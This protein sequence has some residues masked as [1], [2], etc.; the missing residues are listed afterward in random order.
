MVKV[1]VVSKGG[2]LKESSVKN[3]KEND[4]YK[5]GS[6]I[7]EQIY[8]SGVLEASYDYKLNQQ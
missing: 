6:T 2:S 1:V 3:F 5:K 7:L 4:L 8:Q